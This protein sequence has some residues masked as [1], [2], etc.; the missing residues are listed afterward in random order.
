MR[1]VSKTRVALPNHAM[2]DLTWRNL[3]QIGPPEYDESGP[4]VRS[5]DPEAASGLDPMDNPFPD[6]LTRL[7]PPEDYEE[8]VRSILP[9]W[10]KFIGA[11][12][13]VEYMWHAPTVRLLT[14]R[15]RLRPP[16]STFQYPILDLSRARRSSGGHGPRHVRRRQARSPTTILDLLTQPTSWRRRRTNSSLAPA[17]ASAAD[18]GLLRSC[19]V[20]SSHPS[21]CAGRSTSDGTR[22]RVDDPDTVG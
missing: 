8:Q 16:S 15:P 6:A 4:V 1:W 7:T 5:R 14:A 10:Q 13:Y 3:A 18:T 11:D 21:I 17:V 22:R 19:R 2:A 9:P 20:T 12:D